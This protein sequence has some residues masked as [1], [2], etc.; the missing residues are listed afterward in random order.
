VKKTFA[1]IF[2]ILASGPA[3]AADS[4]ALVKFPPGMAEHMLSNMRDHLLALTEIQQ[5]MGSGDFRR[6]AEVAENRLGMSSL[7]A[8]GAAHMAGLMP[9]EMREIG[10]QMHRAA[11]R[12][13]LIAEE[14]VANEDTRTVNLALARVTEK[15]VACHARF[16]T[17]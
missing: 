17:H 6:A 7:K 15:C 2:F 14:Q 12:F 9:P 10:T 3:T 1:L 5:A 11:S 8:H 16:R 13:A 4:R